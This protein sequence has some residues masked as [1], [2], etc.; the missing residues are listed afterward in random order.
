VKKNLNQ[1]KYAYYRTKKEGILIELY[2]KKGI[3]KDESI[4]FCY[5]LPSHP[6]DRFPFGLENFLEEG[7]NLIYPHYEGTFGS[8]GVCTIENAVDTVLST[9]DNVKNQTIQDII[10]GETVNIKSK[11]IILVG[12]SFGGSIALVSTAKS[13][14]VNDVI[15]IAAPTDYRTHGQI[16]GVHEYNLSELENE[17]TTAYK[18]EWRIDFRLWNKFI[19]GKMDLNAVDYVD[20]LKHKNVFLIHGTADLAVDVQRSINLF[21]KLK[22]GSGKHELEVIK[23]GHLGAYYIGE[24]PIYLKIMNW[25]K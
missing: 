1:G 11:R 6:F 4:I 3:S 10:T 21:E 9:I 14:K 5:G 23:K 16:K 18:N 13:E 15:S 22:T 25:L 19:E 12:G 20:V 24:K 8:D 7:Y 17:I 2:Q